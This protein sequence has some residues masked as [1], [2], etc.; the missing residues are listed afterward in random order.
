MTY[1]DDSALYCD[2]AYDD[3]PFGCADG[4]LVSDAFGC[5]RAA[6]A[7]TSLISGGSAVKAAN[8]DQLWA[9]EDLVGENF[10]AEFGAV[11]CGTGEFS[12]DY[13]TAAPTP[14]WP[15]ATTRPDGASWDGVTATYTIVDD[16]IDEDGT[17]V[18][19][20]ESGARADVYY[21]CVPD[22]GGSCWDTNYD[23]DAA[24][25]TRSEELSTADGDAIVVVLDGRTHYSF[26]I[27]DGKFNSMPTAAPSMSLRR[28]RLGRGLASEVRRRRGGLLRRPRGLP[29]RVREHELAVGGAVA[30]GGAD[31]GPAVAAAV[32]DRAADG[33]G[34]ADAGPDDG[35][36]R[37]RRLGQPRARR[38]RE[39]DGGARRRADAGAV[40]CADSS[41]WYK[42][43]DPSK[44]CA[45]VA[46]Y[47]PGAARGE[48]AFAFAACRLACGCSAPPSPAPSL[49][50]RPS[51]HGAREDA[52][53]RP[54]A[55]PTAYAARPRRP[56]VALP[57][58][59]G[60]GGRDRGARAHARRS[61][62]SADDR[63]R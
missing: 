1:F 56:P 53:A 48:T 34:G 41:S 47:A 43:G 27:T 28:L 52:T 60:A 38:R 42:K 5:G 33:D 63:S 59:D 21:T 35:A 58:P 30:H 18:V 10:L 24:D 20:T 13:P 7:S 57:A 55:G 40:G 22:D 9:I 29:P 23:Y 49:T 61:V 11:L 44:D 32:A 16:T 54:T 4:A 19:G 15:A 25:A 2:E 62:G 36:R 31:V 50:P 12:W 46:A 37:R 3:H 14:R 45:W 51:A 39:P 6:T 8:C 26:C 17:T